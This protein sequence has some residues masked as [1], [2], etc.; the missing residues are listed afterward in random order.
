MAF[1]LEDGGN[2]TGSFDDGFNLRQSTYIS[3][4]YSNW[5]GYTHVVNAVVGDTDSSGLALGQFG[6]SYCMLI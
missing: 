3:R 6:D 5:G 1:D 2:D 4:E